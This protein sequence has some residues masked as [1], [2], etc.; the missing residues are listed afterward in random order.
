MKACRLR[1]CQILFL[2][3]L[4]APLSSALAVEITIQIVQPADQAF[5]GT[6][7]KVVATVQSLYQLTSVT[8]QVE[9]RQ[10]SLVFSDSRWEGTIS[11][12]GLQR[13]DKLLTVTAFDFYGGTAQIQRTI[14]YDQP[15][16]LVVQ[17]P[18]SETVARPEVRVAASCTDDDPAGCASVTV[19]VSAGDNP[20]PL[21][22]SGISSVDTVVSLDAYEGTIV[23]LRFRATDS[24]GQAVSMD[25]SVYVESSQHLIEVAQVDGRIIDVQGARILFLDSTGAEAV[26]KIRDR[27]S[28]QDIAIPSVAGKTFQYG[29]LTPKGAIFTVMGESVLDA[30]LLEWRDGQLLNLRRPSSPN[31]LVVKGNYAIWSGPGPSQSDTSLFLRDLVSGTTTTVVPSGVGRGVPGGV[32]NWNDVAPNGDV[33]YWIYQPNDSVNVYRYHGGSTTQLTFYLSLWSY[34]VL[35]DGINVLYTQATPC[36]LNR[37]YDIMMYGAEGERTLAAPRSL[38]PIPGLDYQPN[39]G[40]IAFTRIGGDGV[41]Q[42]W[43]RS[44]AGT[45]TQVS[46]FGTPTRIGA[47]GSRGGVTLANNN[48]LYLARPALP[49]LDIASTF[50]GL[51]RSMWQNGKL[52]VTIGRSLFVVD[53]HA[54]IGIYRNGIWYLDANGD[55][56]WNGCGSDSCIEW[57]GDPTDIPVVG[58]WNGDGKT[59]IGVY[60]NGTWY[61]DANGNGLWDGC[62]TDKCIAWGGE[63]GD[64][65]VVGDWNGDGK[66]K[67]GIYRNGT[68]YLDYNGNGAWDGCATDK[69]IP[70]GGDP[71]DRVVLGDWNG[72][73][74]TKIGIYRNGTWYLDAN[75]NGLWDG[76]GVDNCIAWGDST[77]SAVVGNWD[78][79]IN[80]RVK[81]GIYRP[82]TGT[83]YL[84][85]NG[86]G[87]WD[88]CATDKCIPWG[89]DP[90]DRVVLGDWNGDGT[91]KIGIYRNGTWYLDANGNGLWDGCAT[92]KCIAWG[93]PGDALIVGRW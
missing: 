54:K 60:R 76:C 75:G 61:L 13:G 19:E 89:G 63:A 1:V 15:P 44:P 83:W 12:L 26:L 49:P 92:D 72:D 38:E 21:L 32:G 28:G 59:K 87:V 34:N 65:P 73:G 81:I 5:V 2:P 85:Y 24:A 42:V 82:S 68:W 11:L 23:Q 80:G 14:R 84:D 36:C 67:I 40:W 43:V 41:S 50:D 31:S 45:E 71:V 30:A 57:G 74:T 70:W 37:T 55:E 3:F 35:T 46:H 62:A 53:G 39:N 8:A 16:T 29:F 78:G 86:N 77:D 48:R 56:A 64:I 88:G 90:V 91:T 79:E 52:F 51:A 4:L 27:S 66:T 47:L 20:G 18:L 33:A 58:D 7:L 93:D 10:A 17:A 69:C 9:S 22:A 6:D 25:R